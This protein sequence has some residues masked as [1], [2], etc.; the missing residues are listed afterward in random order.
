MTRSKL[1]DI[2][3][4]DR[5]RDGIF[6][7]EFGEETIPLILNY[8]SVREAAKDWRTFSSDA[9]FRVPIPSEESMRTVRQL[10][11]ELDPP[12]HKK[13]RALVEPFFTKPRQSSYIE[14][15]DALIDEMIED[16][17]SRQQIEIVREFALPLQSRALA[18]LLGMPESEAATWIS[19]GTHVFHDGGDSAQNGSVLERYI[20]AQLDRARSSPEGEDFFGVLARSRIDDRPLSDDEVLGV[21]NLVF[22]G[23]R[24][25][26][27]NSISFI[28]GYFAKDT[29]ALRDIAG[30][31]QQINLATE[32]FVRAISPL[33]HIGRVCPAGTKLGPMKVQPDTRVSLCWAAANYDDAVFENPE[34]IDLKRSPNPHIGFGSGHHACLGAA[35]ARAILRGLIRS[36]AKRPLSLSIVDEVAKFEDFGTLRRHVGYERLIVSI[37]D[38]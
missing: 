20:R 16:A 18:Y 6:V 34:Q 4:A 1:K 10:P 38:A 28:I 26:I 29:R 2:F 19:W 27:I 3:K 22:A 36:L 37:N 14:R 31:Q 12:Q 17:I 13:F 5:Q 9:P 25:T 21:A 15:L 24:D 32:E 11:I 35:Q 7:A 23:G 30:D 8:R 33:T